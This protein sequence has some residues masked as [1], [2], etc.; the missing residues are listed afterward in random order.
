MEQALTRAREKKRKGEFK[1]KGFSKSEPQR[2]N[3]RNGKRYSMG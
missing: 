1:A 2:M 3:L